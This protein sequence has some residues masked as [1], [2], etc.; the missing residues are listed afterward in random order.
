MVVRERGL[1]GHGERDDRFELHRI[2]DQH[3]PLR[4]PQPA[5]HR[6]RRGLA[7]L[8]DQQPPEVLPP[9]VLEQAG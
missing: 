4:P 6:L 2:A 9:E 7:R 3:S 1:G 8:V 5:D